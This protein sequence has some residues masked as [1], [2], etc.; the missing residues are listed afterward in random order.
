MQISRTLPVA[1]AAVASLVGALPAAHAQQH[2]VFSLV[3]N[4]PLAHLQRRGGLY[5]EAG[6]P[7]M[8]RYV[9]FGRP[10]PVWRLR[11]VEDGRKVAVP[12]AAVWLVAPL[13]AEQAK[14]NTVW[15]GL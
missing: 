11:A 1:V 7:G 4:R 6:A 2:P 10:L 15:V 5:I 9:H 14:S 3:D 8:A 13:T 12:N